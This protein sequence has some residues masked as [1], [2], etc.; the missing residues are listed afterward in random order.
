MNSNRAHVQKWLEENFELSQFEIKEMPI[1]PGGV[2]LKDR[3]GETMLVYWD[4]LAQKIKFEFQ[5]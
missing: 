3:D 2:V 5:N 4:I 1:V